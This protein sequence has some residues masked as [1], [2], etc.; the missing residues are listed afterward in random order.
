MEEKMK[1]ENK[2]HTLLRYIRGKAF[3]VN[4][5][6]ARRNY[7]LIKLQPLYRFMQP[8]LKLNTRP[9]EYEEAAVVTAPM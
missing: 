7:L 2:T 6:M 4:C 9:T 3:S 1:R 5:P 8:E